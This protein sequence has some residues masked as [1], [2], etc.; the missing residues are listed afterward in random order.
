M[1][2]QREEILAKSREAKQDEGRENAEN[3]GMVQGAKIFH[4]LCI[5]CMAVAIHW[6]GDTG[7]ANVVITVLCLQSVFF[8]TEQHA[9]YKFTRRRRN[10]VGT[11]GW[12]FMSV[13]FFAALVFSYATGVYA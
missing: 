10:L 4:V 9:R 12:G 13:F 8:A 1:D 6:G 2:N 7:G 5:A 3:R 11:I